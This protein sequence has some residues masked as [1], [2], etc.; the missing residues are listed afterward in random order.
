MLNGTVTA[1]SK[2]IQKDIQHCK[3]GYEDITFFMKTI[4]NQYTFFVYLHICSR[5]RKG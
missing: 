2:P 1:N 4:L 3:T 5:S